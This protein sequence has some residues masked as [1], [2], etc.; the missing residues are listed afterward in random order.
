MSFANP[1]ESCEVFLSNFI[2]FCLP[3]SQRIKRY[4]QSNQTYKAFQKRLCHPPQ[5]D[6]QFPGWTIH[7][8][9]IYNTLYIYITSIWGRIK[10]THDSNHCQSSSP[11]KK[12]T[13]P[14]A[15][16]FFQA[17]GHS[18]TSIPPRKAASTGPSKAF[19]VNVKARIAKITTFLGC[20]CCW[21][22][23]SVRETWEFYSGE[24]V[25]YLKLWFGKGASWW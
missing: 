24:R 9:I 8:I 20:T 22:P 6:D 18:K 12:N 25:G 16:S 21:A 2:V 14:L 17:S 7:H 4:R 11:L 5:F 10:D 13:H 15:G 1:C 23:K 19:P 3:K